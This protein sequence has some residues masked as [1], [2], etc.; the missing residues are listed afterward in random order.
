[1]TS[2]IFNSD[3]F[4]NNLNDKAL[5]QDDSIFPCNSKG[6][7]FL[8]KGDQHLVFSDFWIMKHKLTRLFTKGSKCRK[9]KC[10]VRKS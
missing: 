6:S 3:K 10:F 8:D 2:T 4:I 9:I 7:V 5:L 1:M